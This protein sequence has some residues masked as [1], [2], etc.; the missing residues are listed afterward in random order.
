MKEVDIPVCLPE[1]KEDAFSSGSDLIVSSDQDTRVNPSLE[2]DYILCREHIGRPRLPQ[3]IQ[4]EGN[5]MAETGDAVGVYIGGLITM[6]NDVRNAVAMENSKI[7]KGRVG[8]T[9]LHLEHFSWA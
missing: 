9:Y 8:A 4:E 5:C 7:V 2:R 1:K 3:M 6:Q